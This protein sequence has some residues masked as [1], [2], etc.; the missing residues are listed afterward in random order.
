[1]AEIN[2]L[3]FIERVQT[4]I[5]TQRP[6]RSFERRRQRRQHTAAAAAAADDDDDDDDAGDRCCQW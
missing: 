1:M 5:V 2:E 6:A 4:Y 3:G